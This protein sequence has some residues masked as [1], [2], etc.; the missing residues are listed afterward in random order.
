V[1]RGL[2]L[3]YYKEDNLIEYTEV[4]MRASTIDRLEK[5]KLEKIQKVHI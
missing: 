2:S 4:T 1:Y 3:G 5:D